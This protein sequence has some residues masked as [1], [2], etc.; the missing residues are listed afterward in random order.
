M[1]PLA[2]LLSVITRAA[3]NRQVKAGTG[4]LRVS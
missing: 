2:L 1:C 4:S 3:G